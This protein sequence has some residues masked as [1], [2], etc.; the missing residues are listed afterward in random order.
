MAN[1][2]HVLLE[3]RDLTDDE[4]KSLSNHYTNIIIFDES[5][6]GNSKATTMNFDLLILDVW[7]V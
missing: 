7:L 1:R 3:L 2:R 4:K 6:N 5:V